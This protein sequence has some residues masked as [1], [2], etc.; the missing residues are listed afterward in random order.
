MKTLR[1][2]DH[3]GYTA[4]AFDETEATTAH[5]DEARALFDRLTKKGTPVFAVN[6]A[7]GA[8]DKRVRNFNELENENIIV[9]VIVGG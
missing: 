1:L 7:D 2:M 4:I 8:P 6:R 3:T 9:P 5:R